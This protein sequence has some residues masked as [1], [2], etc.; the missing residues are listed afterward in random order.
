MIYTAHT[1]RTYTAQVTIHVNNLRTY[2]VLL[3]SRLSRPTLRIFP[4]RELNLQH[5]HMG[6]ACLTCVRCGD[7]LACRVFSFAHYFTLF[8]TI[9]AYVTQNA[10][11]GVRSARRFD[12]VD[13]ELVRG[14]FQ[15]LQG[16]FVG[17][18]VASHASWIS[19]NCVR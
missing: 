6:L 3:A 15:P 9:T 18:V 19:E 14:V 16:L 10:L 4:P 12:G 2:K 17:F 13:P 11:P 7:T 5:V 1:Y 8:L